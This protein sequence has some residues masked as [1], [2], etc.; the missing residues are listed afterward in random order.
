MPQNDEKDPEVGTDDAKVDRIL[1]GMKGA[2]MPDIL[3]AQSAESKGQKFAA[4][5]GSHGLKPGEDTQDLEPAVVVDQTQQNGI[6]AAEIAKISAERRERSRRDA[7]TS[8]IELD[9]IPKK[10]SN[11]PLLV[12]L[13]VFA[14][15]VVGLF[16]KSR[17][18][19]DDDGVIAPATAVS[20]LETAQP[21][22]PGPP[23]VTAEAPP[24]SAA[25]TSI[26]PNPAQISAAPSSS[27]APQHSSSPN[28]ASAAATGSADPDLLLFKSHRTP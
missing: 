16:V 4:Y 17:S 26:E 12:F 19:V 9:R 13:V 2:R 14:F 11:A 21:S 3:K 24:A 22:I 7:T 23:A 27:A 5:Q 25:T 1:S 10:K 18:H 20:V 28:H 8:V 6:S 15:A